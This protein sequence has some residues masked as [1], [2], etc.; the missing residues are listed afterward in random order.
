M[1]LEKFKTQFFVEYYFG[2]N[3]LDFGETTW[4]QIYQKSKTWKNNLQKWFNDVWLV[5]TCGH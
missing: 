5:Y 2:K 4:M 1:F 3:G